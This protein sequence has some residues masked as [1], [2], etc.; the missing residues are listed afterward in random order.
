M[1]HFSPD[2]LPSCLLWFYLLASCCF[3]LL[4]LGCL[5]ML[6]TILYIFIKAKYFGCAFIMLTTVRYCYLRKQATLHHTL[7][8]FALPNNIDIT[9]WILPS[10]LLTF[11]C[12]ATHSYNVIN[13]LE[14]LFDFSL[15]LRAQAVFSNSMSSELLTPYVM[16]RIFFIIF[17]VHLVTIK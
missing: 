10:V 16:R 17:T 6:S 7:K 14:K 13:V 3:K 9:R 4:G 8:S 1:Y 2:V 12:K 5:L 15:S 11:I